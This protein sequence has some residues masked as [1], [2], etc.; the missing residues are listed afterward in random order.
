MNP[1]A[2]HLGSHDPLEVISATSK[3]LKDFA[4]ALGAAGIERPTAPGKWSAREI[5]CHLAD[6]EIVFAYRLRQALA[7][8]HHIIQPFDQDKWASTYSGYDA[9]S[10]LAAFS[11]VRKWNLDFIR[12]I[13]AQAKSKA[14][15]HPER[16]EMQLYTIVETMAGHDL[17]HLKQ[18]EKIAGQSATA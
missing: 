13:P 16:G 7:E 15:T 5:L 6:C 12:K 2:S 17:N 11:S 18:I 10:A 3:K 8:D 1:Y 14:V 9:A 4:T